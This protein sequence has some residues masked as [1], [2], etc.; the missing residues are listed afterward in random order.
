[1]TWAPQILSGFPMMAMAALG[2]GYPL[3]WTHL[4]LPAHWAEQ[5]YVLAP[6]L[7]AP[8]FTYA[9]VRK[10]GRT[11]LASL[12]AALSFGY[13]GLMTNTY[14]MNG[15]PTNG[16][17]WLPLLLLV[18]ENAR[19]ASLVTS[20]ILATLIYVLSILTGHG[21]SFMQVGML[22]L[23]YGFFVA[24]SSR[25]RNVDKAETPLARW[26]PFVVIFVGMVL[27]A[28][29][30]AFQILETVQAA[31]LSIRNTL[32]YDTFIAGGFT[33]PEAVRSFGAPLYHYLEVT[34]YQAPIVL[35]LALSAIVLA[36][37]KREDRDPRVFFWTAVALLAFVLL[38]GGN[39]PLYRW[40]YHVPIFNL[41]RRPSRYAFEWTFALSVLA[42]FGWDAIN[43]RTTRQA[44]HAPSTLA[45][46]HFVGLGVLL[47]SAVIGFG[48]WWAV[49]HSTTENSY[50]LW[51]LGFTTCASFAIVYGW[52]A[53][54]T[55]WRLRVVTGALLLVCFV[56][57]F[58]LIGRWWPGTAKPAARFNTPA[59][60]T[61][62]LQQFS[63]AEQ[64]V[65]V[66][67][68]GPDEESAQQPRIDALDRTALFGVA[69]V[70]GYEPLFFERYSRALGNV[71]F[72]SVNPRP[73]HVAT[74]TLF[75]S[76][77][78]VLDILNTHHVVTWPG[79]AVMPESN[80]LARAGVR[81]APHELGVTL[82]PSEHVN[83]RGSKAAGDILALVTSLSNSVPVAQETV[84]ARVRVTT[85]DGKVVELNLRAGVDT[86]E[87]AL[88]RPD[89]RAAIQH[90]AAPVFDEVPGDAANSFSAQRYWTRLQLG[91]NVSL[92]RIEI[93]HAGSSAAFSLWKAT[94]YDSQ[95]GRSTPLTK[96]GASETEPLLDP[97]RWQLVHEVDGVQIIRNLRALP[98]AWLV[99]EAEAVDGEE[100]LRRISGESQRPFD[101]RR[102]AL[103]EVASDQLPNLPGGSL[104]TESNARIVSYEPN[105]MSI[106]TSAT[107]PTVLIVSEM[108]YAGWEATVDGQVV[109]VLRTDYLLRGVALPPGRHQV[110]MRYTAPAA[111][112]GAIISLSTLALL[113]GLAIYSRRRSKQ[114]SI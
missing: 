86:A 106:E 43:F 27:A 104:T 17:M 88:E 15:V 105:R 35:I 45:V 21:Q 59:L 39:T 28:G 92:D 97:R 1:P 32:S 53:L 6:F 66:R 99:A 50:L 14:G 26:Q 36:V 77:S 42:A 64:R 3:T 37:R 38:L 40:L 101:P 73:G 51:K 9:Y 12:L 58:I 75:E 4:F 54:A 100:A 81:F 70:G 82:N 79:L 65:Y 103:I 109:P 93:A 11:R 71:E 31:E 34:T 22:A 16:L 46:R 19:H 114:P 83:L 48:W 107:T 76:R 49:K 69:N 80:L 10:I 29:V 2:I 57:P 44:V 74:K 63:P 13:G 56:E 72:D 41:F 60:T 20:V 67:A 55:P 95:T 90:R 78:Q 91:S 5:I 52:R 98:R 87:W 24:V 61:R 33:L 18:I 62:W 108:F 94:L 23:A 85:S 112:T 84:V 68:N 30:S 111:R 8:T 113:G 102:T 25:G 96:D 7:L 47:L 110:E 89:V